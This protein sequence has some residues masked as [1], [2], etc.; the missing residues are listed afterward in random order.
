MS[1]YARFYIL[2]NE[3]GIYLDVDVE[4]IKSFEDIILRGNFIGCE[5][6]C[7]GP[8][9]Y[10][11][12]GL[13]MGCEAGNLVCLDMLNYTTLHFTNS[14]PQTVVH[15]TSKYF[16]SKGVKNINEIQFVNGFWIYPKDYFCPKDPATSILEITNNTR[17]IHHYAASWFTWKTKLAVFIR[18]CF[19]ERV[20]HFLLRIKN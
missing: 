16:H 10:I 15:Y 2:Y 17:T 14:A 7:N 6:M 1:D 3:G 13:G 20:L 12:P 18:N 4:V 8:S 5:N 9:L 19:G 11:A